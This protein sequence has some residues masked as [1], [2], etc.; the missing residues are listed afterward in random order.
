MVVVRVL[1]GRAVVVTVGVVAMF[2]DCSSD[3]Y[4]KKEIKI[5]KIAL[6]EQTG[7]RSRIR[8]GVVEYYLDG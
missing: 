3:V 4:R 2:P 6:N 1:C 5:D 7:K 8:V